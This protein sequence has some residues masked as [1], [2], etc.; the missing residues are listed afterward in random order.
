[1]RSWRWRRWLITTAVPM[2]PTCVTRAR[3]WSR[4]W[5]RPRRS[6]QGRECGC[7]SPT[8]RRVGRG[9]PATADE[10][11]RNERF[12]SSERSGS[13]AVSRAAASVGERRREEPAGPVLGEG[14]SVGEDYLDL[15]VADLQT[16]EQV[17]DEGARNAF[18]LVQR[19]VPAFDDYSRKVEFGEALDLEGE[20]AVGQSG[21]EVLQALA[22]D[23]GEQ[24]TLLGP[25]RVV[26]GGERD[27]LGRDVPEGHTNPWG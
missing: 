23:R 18:E 24:R 6:R 10:R 16:R 5:M 12:T 8:A 14:T 19:R 9:N 20:G 2:R 1:M 17:G 11:S 25:D 3:G 26:T 7:R 15:G 13:S 4:R 22:L 27:P 21:G